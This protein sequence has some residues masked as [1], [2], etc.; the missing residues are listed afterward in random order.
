M[1]SGTLAVFFPALLL[2]ILGLPSLLAA[3][4]KSRS[5]EKRAIRLPRPTGFPIIVVVT[6]MAGGRQTKVARLLSVQA[7]LD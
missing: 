5:A 4:L 7:N 3:P 2:V 6:A 1:A